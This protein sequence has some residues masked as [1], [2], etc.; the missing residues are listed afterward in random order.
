[1]YTF[2]V[3]PIAGGGKTIKCMDKVDEYL[4][5]KHIP[6]EVIYTKEPGHATELASKLAK[7]ND[8]EAVIA[9]GGDGTVAE[10]AAG[11]LDTKCPMGIL[12]GGTGND[13]RRSFGIPN[14]IKDAVDIVLSGSQRLADTVK[15]NG[16]TF[17]NIITVGFDVEV[18]RR[19]PFYGIF[20][21]ASYTFAAI[22]RAFF[23]RP[24]RAEFTIDG[25]SEEKEFLL[26]AAGCGAYYGGGM[27]PLPGANPYDGLLDLCLIDKA[28]T[29]KILSL[30]PKYKVGEHEEL[31]IA[32]FSKAKHI[33]IVL[34]KP[35]AINAD[36]DILEPTSELEYQV[37]PSNLIIISGV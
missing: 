14:D 36:G 20:G 2:I 12:P 16:R 10:V 11:L 21:A 8:T 25:K 35:L 4:N 19:A 6:F 31:D 3:N 32:H 27:N 13:Y 26:F 22:D 33:K 1:M 18:V 24:N 30:L 37:V 9:V 5:H 23:A 17:L 7:D 34:D 29:F 28:S 15:I